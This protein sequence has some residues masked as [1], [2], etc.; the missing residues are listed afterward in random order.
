MDSP[1]SGKTALPTATEIGGLSRSEAMSSRILVAI[2]CACAESVSGSTTANS[3]PP[4]RAGVST[5]RQ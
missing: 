4:N 3:S 5:C 2:C 1:L